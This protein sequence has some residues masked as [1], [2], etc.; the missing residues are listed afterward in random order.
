MAI[1]RTDYP[2][3]RF[4]V[5]DF[6]NNSYVNPIDATML[7]GKIWI[8][9]TSEN[10]DDLSIKLSTLE[11]IVNKEKN[12]IVTMAVGSG[13]KGNNLGWCSNGM[14]L[15]KA[16]GFIKN[17][18]VV[19]H[20]NCK[21]QFN[22]KIKIALL[23]VNND[24]ATGFDAVKEIES[25]GDGVI[26]VIE[27]NLDVKV[28]QILVVK[29]IGF[30]DNEHNKKSYFSVDDFILGNNVTTYNTCFP[31]GYK[32]IYYPKVKKEKIQKKSNIT[33]LFDGDS[34]TNGIYSDAKGTSEKA[35]DKPYPSI[36]SDILGVNINNVAIP[37]CGLTVK[38]CT[39]GD[40]TT[41]A[42]ER[43]KTFDYS[44]YKIVSIA[45]G[46][47]DY[48][49]NVV[50]GDINDDDESTFYGALN[51]LVKNILTSN[52]NIYIMFIT[53]IYRHRVFKNGSNDTTMSSYLNAN[54]INLTLHD[55]SNAIVNVCDKYGIACYDMRKNNIANDFNYEI[56]LPDKL[57]PAKEFYREYAEKVSSF[58]MS[59]FYF[60]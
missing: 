34:I 60:D 6:S 19:T 41:A 31:I 3:F 12:T 8:L 7:N 35:C 30:E 50:L 37:G 27:L 21:S 42:I 54:S 53:P 23:T 11:T 9:R 26:Q 59:K 45:I 38:G 47:N 46:T 14:D 32:V 33:I 48:G 55:Y 20:K 24:I 25:D 49:S 4:Y 56:K 1:P 22:N 39:N 2:Y 28:N 16:D 17:I 52:P 36:V 57:H 15:F 5:K 51:N 58:I 13:F 43:S 18:T 40:N 44:Q 10:I 29:G